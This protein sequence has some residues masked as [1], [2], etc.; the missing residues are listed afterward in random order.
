MLRSNS[1][2]VTSK[3]QLAALTSA[4]R[5]E[6]V[7]V[8]TQMGTVSIAELAETL[9]RPP[10][11]LYY[12]LHILVR[13][14]LVESAGSRKTGR[15]EETLFRAVARN[16]RIDYELARRTNEKALAAVA[17]SMLRL[18]IRDFRRAIRNQSVVVSGKDRELW[19]ARKTGWLRKSD[20][21]SVLASIERLSQS[22]SKPSGSGQLYG[23]TILLTPLSRRRERK[24][25]R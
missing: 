18:G 16:L 17:G 10:D 5:Q 6:I 4:A 21:H 14:G 8:L 11:A 2:V 25:S 24:N 12:H 3:K 19:A 9:D 1:H 23:I 22:V 15:R 20:L 13:A 7:D